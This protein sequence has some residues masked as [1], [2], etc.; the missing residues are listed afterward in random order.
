MFAMS[1]AVI[2]ICVWIC[3]IQDIAGQ[4]KERR[5]HGQE[6]VPAFGAG[7][8]F[9]IFFAMIISLTLCGL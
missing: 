2:W 5:K 8:L 9:T 7:C 6:E 4:Y 3:F 1:L